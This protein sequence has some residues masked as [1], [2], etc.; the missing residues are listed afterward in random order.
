MNKPNRITSARALGF[1]VSAPSGVKSVVVSLGLRTVCVA[2]WTPVMCRISPTG[3]D[4]GKQ[5]LRAVVTDMA[6]RT[7]EVSTEVDVPK[8][9]PRALRL[10]VSKAPA[11]GGKLRRTISGELMRPSSVTPSDGCA[12]TVTVVLRAGGRTFLN[13]QLRLSKSCRFAASVT[14]DPPGRGQPRFSV[15]VSFAGNDVLTATSSSRRFL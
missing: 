13:R 14:D 9:D 4:V 8:L 3:A 6:G 11:K 12:G 1:D 5:T 15:T 7:A 10:N 2:T